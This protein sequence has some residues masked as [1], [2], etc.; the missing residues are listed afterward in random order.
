MRYLFGASTPSINP[1]NR[2]P[3]WRAAAAWSLLMA[4]C[5]VCACAHRWAFKADLSSVLQDNKSE[6]VK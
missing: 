2:A 5:L 6:A 3:L 1:H 4:I